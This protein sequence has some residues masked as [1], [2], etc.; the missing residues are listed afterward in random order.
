VIAYSDLGDLGA[1]GGADAR[2]LVARHAGVLGVFAHALEVVCG[3]V[4]IRVAHAC[5]KGSRLGGCKRTARL[6]RE[7]TPQ[8]FISMRTSRGPSARRCIFR[9]LKLHV[10]S[11]Q[12]MHKTSIGSWL[13]MAIGG[14]VLL[15]GSWLVM[16]AL[17]LAS[18]A[19]SAMLW[20][21]KI[22]GSSGRYEIYRK[23]RL[24]GGPDGA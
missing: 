24:G 3:D 1:G 13:G 10:A 17:V 2:E 21:R 5:K 20:R 18:R 12:A 19:R 23:I 7:G 8:Y 16:L 6:G 14:L 15:I 22:F 4:E 9:G 11:S